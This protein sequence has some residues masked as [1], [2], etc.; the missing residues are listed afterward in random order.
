M[1]ASA[2][3][4]LSDRMA[5]SIACAKNCPLYDFLA[6]YFDHIRFRKQGIV[7]LPFHQLNLVRRNTARTLRA[8]VEDEV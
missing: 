4:E 3:M 6:V 8:C 1:R 5:W 7:L 2:S